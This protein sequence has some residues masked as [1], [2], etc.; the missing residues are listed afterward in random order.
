MKKWILLITFIFIFYLMPNVSYCSLETRGFNIQL[1]KDDRLLN[2]PISKTT[3]W[4]EVKSGIQLGNNNFLDLRYSFSPTIIDRE[5]FITVSINGRPL[6]S[7]IMSQR[8]KRP[9]YWRINIS[10][11]LIKKGFNEISIITRHRSAEGLCKDIDN[12]ANWVL[13]HNDSFLHLEIL[14]NKTYKIS[15]Y[16]YPFLEYLDRE[17]VTFTFYLPKNFSQEELEAMLEVANG[18]GIREKYKNLYLK[19]ST[20]DP[21]RYRKEKQILIG[22]LSKWNILSKDETFRNLEENNGL[23]YLLSLEDRLQLYISGKKDGLSKAVSYINDPLQTSITEK[24]PVVV[25]SIPAKEESEARKEGLIRLKD[26]GYESVVLSGVFHQNTSFLLRLPSGFEGIGNGSFIELQFSHSKILEPSKSSITIYINGIPVKSE[27]LD[28]GNAERG[29]LRVPFPKEELDKREWFIEIKTYHNLLEVDCNKRYDEIAW[30]KIEGDSFIYLVKE[31]RGFYPDLRDIWSIKGDRDIVLWLSENPSDEEL[32]LSA[33][34]SASLGQTLGKI[35]KW[36]IFLGDKIDEDFLK[37]K[38][39]IFMGDMRD[40][41][42]KRISDILWVTPQEVG[43]SI[44]KDLGFSLDGFTT[45]ALLQ[46]NSSPWNKDKAMYS[47]IYKDQDTLGRLKR[48]L[49]NSDTRDKIYGQL[50]VIT[51][52]GEVIS[53]T[54]IRE[55][56]A[57][58]S[59]F[60]RQPLLSY[61]IVLLI[62]V[63][64]TLVTIIFIRRRQRGV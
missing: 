35:F 39:V 62:A 11:D 17:P 14:E 6:S 48:V 37:D 57:L 28:A 43:F 12:D 10:K 31:W 26:L 24:N 5:S 63:L 21:Y 3:L 40:K 56:R 46:A 8:E 61:L 41:R 23:I 15:D 16:P 59:I 33:T 38:N 42:L 45:K 55:K 19:V 44:K 2:L 18:L 30:T 27:R 54:L 64:I 29:T 32:S 60:A 7:R 53:S 34:L 36:R 1:F 25:T 47:I 49:G 51:G 50:S 9:V 13:I 58:F 20:E 52:L 22:E 4:F